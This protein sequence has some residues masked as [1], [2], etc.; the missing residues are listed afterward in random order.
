MDFVSTRYPRPLVGNAADMF[1]LVVAL[2][3]PSLGEQLSQGPGQRSRQTAASL[4]EG[5][6][7]PAGEPPPILP[8]RSQ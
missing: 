6:R 1:L 2:V 4:R 3:K 5:V 8:A 7:K